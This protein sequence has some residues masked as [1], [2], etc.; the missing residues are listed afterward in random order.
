MCGPEKESCVANQ[1]LKDGEYLVP[2]DGL[3]ADIADDSLEQNLEQN[4][5]SLK[6]ST[7]KGLDGCIYNILSIKIRIPYSGKRIES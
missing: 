6:Q 1:T 3:Y 4:M 5:I 2:C 7:M